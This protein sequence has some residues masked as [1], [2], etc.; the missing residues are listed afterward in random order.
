[1]AATATKTTPAAKSAPAEKSS[2]TPAETQSPE[3]P[4][5]TAPTNRQH[6]DA[7]TLAKIKTAPAWR[8]ADGDT[9][10]GTIVTI[11]KRET[12]EY[13]AY[14]CV[15][16]A[17]EGSDKFTAIHAFHGVLINELREMKAGPGMDVTVLYTGK[18]TANKLNTDGSEKNY[19]GYSVVPVGG[20]ELEV[21]EI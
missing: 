7:S 17:T 10:T 11:V 12:Q 19:H 2:E 4:A 1:M 15:I 14:P 3:N 5:A 6:F 20:A 8:P 21:F 18:R 13:G 16:L 9:I